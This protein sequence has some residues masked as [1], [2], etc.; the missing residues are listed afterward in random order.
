[1]SNKTFAE[2]RED[3]V[4]FLLE[5]IVGRDIKREGKDIAYGGFDGQDYYIRTISRPADFPFDFV[6]DPSNFDEDRRKLNVIRDEV[7]SF[8]VEKNDQGIIPGF[9]FLAAD[10]DYK[11]MKDR[12][13]R[14]INRGHFLKQVLRS[15]EHPKPYFSETQL[16]P[17]ELVLQQ[18]YRL[19]SK[20]EF[21]SEGNGKRM[22][23]RVKDRTY[24]FYP[25]LIHFNPKEGIIEVNYFANFINPLEFRIDECPSC[26]LPNGEEYDHEKCKGK[27]RYIEWRKGRNQ[28]RYH[29]LYLHALQRMSLTSNKKQ[30]ERGV[31]FTAANLG[32]YMP[33][34][35][36][37][38]MR[39]AIIKR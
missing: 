10:V 6:K 26:N 15:D 5:N 3:M 8:I 4:N 11:Q 23:A 25:E 28:A 1:M 32:G 7:I 19:N 20:N 27:G 36:N 33:H 31:R 38:E 22:L 18:F 39:I 17:L 12:T 21:N 24:S 9:V 2:R 34:L 14:V 37:Q 30:A 16:Q 29:K 13:K 35:P